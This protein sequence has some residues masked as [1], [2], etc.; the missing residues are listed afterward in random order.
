MS[1]RERARLGVG[2]LLGVGVACAL[3]LAYHFQWFTT[4]QQ[5]AHDQFARR[6][7]PARY[8]DVPTRFVI[9]ALDSKT[10]QQLGRWS[11]W[12]RR[13]YAQVID[14]L[15]AA[16]AR[17]IALDIGFFEPGPGDA[18]LADAIQRAGNVVLPVLGGLEGPPAPPPSYRRFSLLEMPLPA[19]RAGAAALGHANILPDRDGTVRSIPLVAQLEDTVWPS[20]ALAVVAEYLRQ[21]PLLAQAPPTFTFAGRQVPIAPD[22]SLRIN[23][24]GPPSQPDGQ[25]TF[26]TVSF[27]DVLEGRVAPAVFSDKIVWV[28]LLGAQGFADDYWTPVSTT[29]KMAGVEIHANAAAMLVRAAFLTPE[30]PLVTGAAI[31]L[32]A[33]AASLLAAGLGVLKGLVVLAGLVAGYL[34]VSSFAFDQGQLLNLVYPLA[35]PALAYVAMATYLVVFEQRHGRFLRSAMGRYLSP[36]VLEAIIREPTLLRL[37]GEKREMTVLFADIRGFTPLAEQLDPQELVA[38]LNEFLTAMTHVIYR[39][40]GV[41]DKYMGDALMAFWN[42]PVPQPDHARRACLAALEMLDVLEALRERWRARGVPPLAIGIGIN[43]GWMAVGN[44]GSDVRFDYTVVGDAVNLAARLEGLN[45][46]YRTSIVIS[47]ETFDAVRKE[48][49]VVRFLDRVA[50]QGRTQPVPIYELLGRPGDTQAFPP[51]LAAVW[52]EAL[53]RYR[54]RQ[55]AAA[56]ECFQQLLAA[57]PGDGPS[58]LYWERCQTLLQAPPPPDWD[59]VYVMIHK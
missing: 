26:L 34:A 44:M 21:P 3:L 22:Y 30:D 39:Y 36:A 50:V 47:Q 57:W 51:A 15:A 20:L 45:K 41:L 52:E 12:D 53:R 46:E 48:G 7:A 37:G 2:L 28:G 54:A 43:T 58:A 31:V 6:Q 42:S 8:G 40:D 59:G 35:A 16:G 13:Y 23:Y 11:G 29:G 17:V 27:V 19:L 33:L 10:L 18:D 49:F 55:F 24:V 32:L 56:A 5:L 38:L 25:Q 9:V 14:T 4:L 1:A